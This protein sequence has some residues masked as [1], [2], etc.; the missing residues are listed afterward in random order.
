MRISINNRA[1]QEEPGADGDL[2]D[3]LN[4]LRADGNIP[5]DEVVVGLRVDERRFTGDDLAEL[6]DTPLQQIAE[7][8]VA[9]DDV[10]GYASRILTDM[11]SMVRVLRQAVPR[12]ALA[13]RDGDAEEANADL[14]R[15]LQALQNAFAC[16]NQ[17]QNT[18]DL[19]HGPAEAS[20]P[21]AQD[22][23]DAL[24]L[25]EAAQQTEDWDALAEALEEGMLPALGRLDEVMEMM[26][27]EF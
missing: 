14:F 3:L 20:E 26:R 23:S 4:R 1:V 7:V 9:T 13:L 24:D 18:C 6:A 19:A 8:A 11:A 10:R 12:V 21:L 16:L 5:D 17:L 15:L 25:V 22:I 2:G 27:D